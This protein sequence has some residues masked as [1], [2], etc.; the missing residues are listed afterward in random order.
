MN[1]TIVATALL[2]R[3]KAVRKQREKEI[4]LKKRARAFRRRAFAAKQEK[5]RLCFAILLALT[6]LSIKLPTPRSIWTRQRSSYWW[7][8]IVFSTFTNDQWMENFRMSKTT[9]VMICNELRS[10]LKKSSTT[11]RQPIPVEKRV[12]ISLWFMATGTDYRTIGH[13]FGVSKASVCLAI[14]QVCR[15]ILTTLLERYIKWPS[16][17]NLKNI[18]SGFKHKFGFPQ[19]VGAVDGT[20][21][22]IISPEDYPADYYNR[23][24]WHSVLM[25]GTVDHLGIFIDIYIGWP[26]RVH[27][28]RVFVNS[29]LYKKGQEG[30][31]LPNWKESI[32]GQEVPLVLLGDPAYP[33]LPWLMK[34]YS[35]NGHL[36][37]DQKRFNYRLSKGRV[38]VEHAYGRLKGRWRCLLKR[39][40]VSVEF[41]PDV[42]AACCVLH[43]ICEIHGETFNNEL[44]DGIDD[45]L[46]QR[47]DYSSDNSQS[48]ECTRKAISGYFIHH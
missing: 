13:L 44:L 46:V 38:V 36:T 24:G 3:R 42:V 32:E 30:T 11:M 33:L 25:Q 47:S 41:V 5:Q 28:A 26:G 14:R 16:G 21:I 31:L 6:T 23:K 29:S 48:A 12:A 43:N 18:I 39:L 20:H 10:S 7:D 4:Y 9:F 15:A 35:D 22:P 8:H 45:T 2:L 1:E 17:E 19:C 34:P 27:D 40:D 37:R